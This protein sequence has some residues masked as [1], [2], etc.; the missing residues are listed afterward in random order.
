MIV[1]VGVGNIGRELLAKLSR[2]F[3]ITCLDSRPDAE[4]VVA[5]IRGKEKTKVIVGDATSRLVLEDARVD[6]S[7]VVLITTT[8]EKINLEVA[9]V[10]H[11]HF[12]PRRVISVG[13]TD[14]GMKELAALGAE[15][16]SIFTASANDVR[17]LIEHQA[18]T[19]HGIGIGK[20]E[21][22]EIEVHPNSRLKNR[23]LGYIAPIR[24]NIGIIYREGNIIVPKPE[25]VLKEK[26]K[27]VVLGDPAVLK[28]VAELLSSEFER[29][30]LEFG[31]SLGVYVTGAEEDEFFDE[32][33]YIYSVFQ[34]DA[35]HFVYSAKAGKLA[36]RHDALAGKY[37]FKETSRTVSSLTPAE[38]LK[39]LALVEGA[40]LGITV[41]SK[42]VFSGRGFP[43]YT[44]A[45]KLSLSSLLHAAKC[46]VVLAAG[47]FPYSKLL[48]PALTDLDFRG[49]IDKA[50]EISHTINT[51][52]FVVTA[53]PS[54][55]IGTEEEAERFEETKKTI[56]NVGFMHKKRLDLEIL[57]GNP[58]LEISRRLREYQLLVLGGDSWS[59][60]GFLRSMLS[61]DVAWQILR[62]SRITTLILPGV[63]EPL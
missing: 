36:D 50:I 42:K 60:S 15:A 2:D 39:T 47:T 45:E 25:T 9:R 5:A 51:E 41:V 13:I 10:L 49:A 43:F 63:E 56:S 44:A 55:Y 1:M 23:P 17:N 16:V 32:V 57:A 31:T 24:W 34:L 27:V 59:G 54:S 53:K 8:A 37:R 21:I 6:E 29:F 14:R 30:P 4:E 22:L 26:D 58:V 33:N 48:V 28:T 38:A 61:P 20:N 35:V 52:L 19:A 40:R 18:K 46:P 11:D 7:D 3:E 12:S 62:R